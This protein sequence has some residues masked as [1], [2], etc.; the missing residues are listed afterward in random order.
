MQIFLLS[1]N[2]SNRHHGLTRARNKARSL[3]FKLRD[4]GFTAPVAHY[5]ASDLI[6]VNRSHLVALVCEP[7]DCAID[8][9]RSLFPLAYALG[10]GIQIVVVGKCYCLSSYYKRAFQVETGHQLI[11]RAQSLRRSLGET[12]G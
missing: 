11:E 2:Y 1:A 9:A 10:A 5:N 7:D 3:R 6:E 12:E 8:S 4:L